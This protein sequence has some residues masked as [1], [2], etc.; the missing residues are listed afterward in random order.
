MCYAPV[1]SPNHVSIITPVLRVIAVT[2]AMFLLILALT[3]CM[4]FSNCK[5]DVRDVKGS[6][7]IGN[8]DVRI[9]I[10]ATVPASTLGVQ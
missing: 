5:F 9:P 6:V 4:S 7:Q 8:K 2:A 1:F 10:D 3:G